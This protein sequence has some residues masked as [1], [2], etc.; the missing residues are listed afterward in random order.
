MPSPPRRW[1]NKRRSQRLIL[2]VPVVAY[3]AQSPGQS[4][5]E[6][7][8]TLVISA[9]GALI[10]LEN[11]IS[12][13]ESVLLK[14]AISGEEQECRVVYTRGAVL[15]ALQKLDLSFGSLR[16]ISGTSPIRQPI[17]LA[18]REAQPATAG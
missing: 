7:T 5:S 1:K 12:P 9:H 11:K 10:N 15:S 8:Y 16:L 18:G 17:G 2:R 6:E 14:H 3:Q 4:L 13:Y